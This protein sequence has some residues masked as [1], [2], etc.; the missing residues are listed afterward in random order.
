MSAK[1]TSERDH[2]SSIT[3]RRPTEEDLVRC[4]EIHPPN[5]GD[6]L[7]GADI[8]HQVWKQLLRHP[9]F[10]SAVF[11]CTPPPVSNLSGGARRTLCASDGRQIIGFGAAMFVSTEFADS[12]LANPRPGI[13]ARFIAAVH[14]QRPIALTAAEVAQSNAGEGLDLLVLYGSWLAPMLSPWENAQVQTLLPLTLAQLTAGYRVNRMFAEAIG[15][16]EVAFVR[17]TGIAREI[18]TFPELNRVINV[19]TPQEAF[20]QP[21]S[22]VRPMFIH[23][24]PLLRL[25]K[26]EQELLAPALAGQTDSE[27]AASLHLTMPAVKARWRSLFARLA[28][29]EQPDLAP[30]FNGKGGRGPQK[31]HRVLAYVREHPE[32]LRP[33]ASNISG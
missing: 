4:L 2:R 11:E 28:Q 29:I 6:E 15:D 32:E 9:L 19:T 30:E 5:L 31:R 16:N 1:P 23:R 22:F 7:T 21:G 10:V 26:T 33:Y 27:L 24:E 8:A 18:A 3:W 25:S 13:N 20:A 12:E 14:E 17:G